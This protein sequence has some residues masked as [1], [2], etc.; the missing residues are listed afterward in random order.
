MPAND[1]W[2]CAKSNHYHQAKR[3]YKLIHKLHGGKTLM[4]A[5]KLYDARRA[6]IFIAIITACANA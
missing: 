6:R 3:L 1:V 2:V 5:Y 4:K